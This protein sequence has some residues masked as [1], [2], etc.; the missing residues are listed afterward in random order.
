MF[1][2]RADYTLHRSKRVPSPST[3]VLTLLGLFGVLRPLPLPS[4]QGSIGFENLVVVVRGYR[5]PPLPISSPGV[6]G[7]PAFI[8]T[9]TSPCLLAHGQTFAPIFIPS[10]HSVPPKPE[11]PQTHPSTESPQLTNLAHRSPGQVPNW[12]HQRKVP[13]TC[14]LKCSSGDSPPL[15]N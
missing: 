1:S 11:P 7:P 9:P 13:F 15:V 14:V 3:V 12:T 8:S 5:T 4:L 10:I 6:V 2:W